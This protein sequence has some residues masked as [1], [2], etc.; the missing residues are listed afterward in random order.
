MTPLD[1][2]LAQLRPT[3]CKPMDCSGAGSFVHGSFQVIILE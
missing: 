3:L 1:G 2:T